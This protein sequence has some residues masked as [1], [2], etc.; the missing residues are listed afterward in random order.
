VPAT[1]DQISSY[2]SVDET[3]NYDGSA[4]KVSASITDTF[5]KAQ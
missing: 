5:G 2:Q 1:Q 4:C 3:S